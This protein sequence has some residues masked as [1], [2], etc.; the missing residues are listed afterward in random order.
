MLTTLALP[1]NAHALATSLGI[2]AS[3]RGGTSLRDREACRDHRAGEHQ[4]GC[5]W[6]G[7]DGQR[8]NGPVEA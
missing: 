1:R 4:A 2:T 5:R 7:P 8:A 6:I 3:I